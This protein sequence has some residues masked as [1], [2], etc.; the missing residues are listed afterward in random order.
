MKYKDQSQKKVIYLLTFILFNSFFVPNISTCADIHLTSKEKAWIKA[1]PKITFASSAYKDEHLIQTYIIDHYFPFSFVNEKGFPDGFGVALIKAVAKVMDVDITF[2][3]SSWENAR[4]K[5][6]EGVIDF[7]PM[8]AYSKLRDQEFDFSPPHMIVYDAIFTQKGKSRLREIT[9]LKQKKIIVMKNDQAHD[10]LLSLDY[11]T[12]NQLVFINDLQEALRKLASGEADA[13]LMPKLIGLF[14]IKQLH[15][16]NL[17]LSPVVVDQYKR[18]FCIAV[19]EGNQELLERLTQGLLIVK[20]TGQYKKI[21]DK[22]LRIFE[23]PKTSFAS[24]LKYL[25]FFILAFTLTGMLLFFWFLSLKRQ[26][27]S[28]TKEL[29]RE[30]KERMLAEDELRIAKESAEVATH[31]K[32]EFLANMSHE[33]RTPINVMLGFLEML[34]DQHAGLL[35]QKQ[36]EYLNNI[37]ESCNRLLFLIDDILDISRVEA[38]KIEINPAPFKLDHLMHRIDKTLISLTARKPLTKRISVSPELPK[39]LI[40]DQYRI[41]QVLKNLIS[42]AVKFTDKGEIDVAVKRSPMDELLFTVS[43]TGI[44]IPKNLQ[45]NLFV[46]FYQIDSS[47]SKNYAGAGLGLAISRELVELMGGKIWFESK[48]GKGSIFCFTHKLLQPDENETHAQKKSTST[49]MKTEYMKLKILLAEDDDLNRQTTTYFLQREGY[50]VTT[51]RNGKEALNLLETDTFD[52]VLMDVQMPGIDGIAATRQ[53]RTAKNGKFN[54]EIPVIAIT[55]Y[56]MQGDRE[57]FLNAGVNDY[58]SKPIQFELLF[59]KMDALLNKWPA[60]AEKDKSLSRTASDKNMAINNHQVPVVKGNRPDFIK[61]I[62][63]FIE[64]TKDDPEFLHHTLKTFPI[65]ISKRL[66][67]LETAISKKDSKGIVLASH[68]FIALFS[69]IF[70]SETSRYSHELQNAARTDDLEKCEQIFFHLKQSMNEIIN[71]IHSM[72]VN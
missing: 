3:V 33:I 48:K 43:D 6:K 36:S 66:Q 56:A 67:I 17:E 7:L 24:I 70:I 58:V 25:F 60:D 72:E 45:N 15:L 39:Y 53:I 49:G 27:A 34:Q 18:P 59:E 62:Q 31:A 9:D 5:L 57:K 51:A 14:L 65:H 42:N 41:E 55:A 64:T 2:Q 37:L 4:R 46:K 40:G 8:M 11:I 30:I 71:Y 63:H 35:N 38:G 16:T 13:A 22:W 68:K 61:D 50:L 52:I 23:P 26:V 29:E 69:V 28:R 12:D 19:A 1:H 44:G 47:Y 20:E 32:S 10:Y 54:P 21:Y